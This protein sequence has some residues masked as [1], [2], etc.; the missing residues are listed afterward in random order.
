MRALFTILI[1]IGIIYGIYSGA[2]AA[3]S[4]FEISNVVEEV[5]PR[6]LPKASESWARSDRGGLIREAVL[7]GATQAGITLDPAGVRVTEEEGSLWVRITYA[8]P[9][10]RIGTRQFTIPI[11]IAHSFP[12]RQ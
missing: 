6:E 8:Y 9:F 10:A 7:K 1:I 11:S 12:V 5:V 2:M 3:W 4:Y